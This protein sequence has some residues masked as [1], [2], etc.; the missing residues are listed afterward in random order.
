MFAIFFCLIVNPKIRFCSRNRFFLE[1]EAVI[2]DSTKIYWLSIQSFLEL[3]LQHFHVN[4]FVS[5]APLLHPLKTSEKCKVFYR[6]ESFKRF[7]GCFTLK[8]LTLWKSE[9]NFDSYFLYLA[10][11]SLHKEK[12]K[13][14]KINCPPG[15]PWSQSMT[16]TW[17]FLFWLQIQTIKK[18]PIL[19]S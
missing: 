16:W 19:M 3:F 15:C 9:P 4:S 6:N 10:K 5:N 14:I 8:I 17:R 11:H 13:I 18:N 1:F 2:L 12:K 7:K